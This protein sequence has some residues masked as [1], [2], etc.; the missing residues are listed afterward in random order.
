[1]KAN[2]ILPFVSGLMLLAQIV[3]TSCM[4]APPLPSVDASA[5]P[6]VYSLPLTSSSSAQTSATFLPF[7]AVSALPL[8]STPS[9]V[10]TYLD[11][12][13]DE[14]KRLIQ[15]PG[16]CILDV[17]TK[18]EYESGHLPGAILIP[19]SEVKVRVGELSQYKRGKILVYCQTGVRSAVASKIL[20]EQGFDFVYNLTGGIAAWIEAQGKVVVPG[21]G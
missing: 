1:M 2:R 11:L 21:C 4:A 12:S 10:S 18:E 17:R 14:A 6:Q 16:L 9:P 20:V 3:P 7:V 13:A 5:S 19:V 8:A 15:E